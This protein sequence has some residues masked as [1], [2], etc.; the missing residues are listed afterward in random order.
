M[1]DFQLPKTVKCVIFDLDGT[2]ADFEDRV[3]SA[4]LAAFKGIGSEKAN[5]WRVEDTR[6]Q[7]GRN[8]D[9]IWNDSGI[10]G[11]NYFRD[12]YGETQPIPRGQTAKKLFYQAYEALPSTNPEVCKNCLFKGATEAINA[13]RMEGV[14]VVLLAAKTEHLLK[15]EAKALGIDSLFDAIYGATD[16]TLMNKPNAGAL[17]RAV[18]GLDI[19]DRTQ[20]IHIGD[21][22]LKDTV[23][24]KTWGATSVIVQPKE[25]KMALYALANSFET[26][27]P[28]GR[29]MN[30][31]GLSIDNSHTNV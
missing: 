23:F 19:K 31:S 22:L 2:L 1:T 30:F 27:Y 18:Q 14:R 25:D 11:F 7:N 20:V 17:D 4:Y 21:N 28:I 3:H 12:R 16:D 5:T 13:A 10:W 29:Q 26:T 15:E 24:A 6:G 9:D 8:P